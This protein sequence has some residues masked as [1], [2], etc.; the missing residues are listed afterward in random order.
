[1]VSLN[2]ASNSIEAVGGNDISGLQG[3]MELINLSGNQIASIAAAAFP[4][5][6]KA[7]TVI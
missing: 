1:M 7:Y 4:G 2:L 5:D 6:T 3:T